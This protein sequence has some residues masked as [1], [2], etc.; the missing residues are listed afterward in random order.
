MLNSVFQL[1][2]FRNQLI[3][4]IATA[5]ACLTICNSITL[6]ANAAVTIIK[7]LPAIEQF[8]TIF[9]QTDQLEPNEKV[10]ELAQFHVS[11]TGK[12][13]G[14]IQKIFLANGDRANVFNGSR[15]E[16]YSCS[17]GGREGVG[18]QEPKH[19][20]SIYEG[21]QFLAL[22]ECYRQLLTGF[23]TTQE[24][25]F[26]IDFR[27]NLEWWAQQIQLGNETSCAA[28]VQQSFDEVVQK[29]IADINEEKQA[30]RDIYITDPNG[31]WLSRLAQNFGFTIVGGNHQTGA[32]QRDLLK[33][34]S[35][36]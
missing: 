21:N 28:T 13:F 4:K 9:F 33:Y 25:G 5:F 36:Q 20:Y 11:A 8:K 2:H 34:T 6:Q 1:V 26:A 3:K 35:K 19:F 12:T 30:D 16:L 29:I 14:E 31:G 22:C 24:Q 7:T 23:G 17:N 15:P 27:P 10:P 32:Q 18:Y